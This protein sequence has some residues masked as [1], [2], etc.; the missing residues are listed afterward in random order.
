ML[1]VAASCY[2]FAC[3]TTPGILSGTVDISAYH[4]TKELFKFSIPGYK[5]SKFD[6][7]SQYKDLG[8]FYQN[9]LRAD[10]LPEIVLVCYGG[11][12]AAAVDNIKRVN[13]SVWEAAEIALR[14]GDNI[15]EGHYMERLWGSLLSKPLES[16]QID[17]LRNH[18]SNE[19]INVQWY[20]SGILRRI[21]H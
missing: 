13:S 11:V 5:N 18:M 3:G 7:V 19:S 20:Y 21:V 12:F 1:R 15:Q 4:E 8:T 16:Y 14:R 6:F 2:G 10:P 9:V 17:G